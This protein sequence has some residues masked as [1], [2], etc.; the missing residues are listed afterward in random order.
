MSAHLPTLRIF[1]QLRQSGNRMTASH[2]HP[3]CNE[4][5]GGE[6]ILDKFLRQNIFCLVETWSARVEIRIA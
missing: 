1:R 4:G 2:T 3:D 5:F 6:T